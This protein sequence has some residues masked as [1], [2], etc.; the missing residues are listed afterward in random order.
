MHKAC[1]GHIW[2]VKAT[3]ANERTKQEPQPT[4]QCIGKKE[5]ISQ[6]EGSQWLA[7]WW[8]VF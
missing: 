2:H 1:L 3:G 5:T 4:Q 8:A 6:P 7:V